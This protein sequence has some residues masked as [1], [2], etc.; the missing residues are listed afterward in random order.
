MVLHAV[1]A[2]QR[3]GDV[4]LEV[5][6]DAD[7]Q[8][9]ARQVVAQRGDQVAHEQAGELDRLGGV[10]VEL[11]VAGEQAVEARHTVPGGGKQLSERVVRRRDAC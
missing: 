7:D 8:A 6:R 11:E 3:A 2:E 9:L 10:E 1:P 4:E 5:G